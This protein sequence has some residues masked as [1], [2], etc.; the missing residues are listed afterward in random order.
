VSGFSRQSCQTS[1]EG[2][3]NAQNMNMH[4][5]ILGGGTGRFFRRVSGRHN[6]PP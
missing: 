2:A 1:H 5:P 3:T 6:L 4:D